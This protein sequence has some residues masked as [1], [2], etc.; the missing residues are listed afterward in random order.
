MTTYFNVDKNIGELIEIEKIEVDRVLQNTLEE[1]MIEYSNPK[2]TRGGVI[3]T[4]KLN[5]MEDMKNAFND[6]K[7]LPPV[8]LKKHETFMYIPPKLRSSGGNPP[9]ITYSILDGRHRVATSILK[10]FT[11]VPAIIF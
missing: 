3:L 11:H 2:K 1:L 4:S 6:N 8:K 7:P 9:K 5:R 10:G